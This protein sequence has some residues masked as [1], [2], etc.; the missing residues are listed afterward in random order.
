MR[1]KGGRIGA[2]GE[3]EARGPGLH[4]HSHSH[5]P[6]INQLGALSN[7]HFSSQGTSTMILKCEISA[8]VLHLFCYN[9]QLVLLLPFTIPFSLLSSPRGRQVQE[10]SFS[11]NTHEYTGKSKHRE[12]ER[13]VQSHLR[14]VSGSHP[15]QYLLKRLIFSYIES[16]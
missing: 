15:E 11:L 12:C 16:V 2:E 8:V 14:L 13:L 6:V 9:C 1:Y 7:Q 3:M 5:Q 10:G 4:P